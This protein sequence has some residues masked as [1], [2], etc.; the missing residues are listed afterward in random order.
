MGTIDAHLPM[1]DTRV[2]PNHRTDDEGFGIV[3]AFDPKTGEKKWEYKMGDST[4]AAV[5]T[6]ASDLLLSGGRDG[7]FSALN[8]RAGELLRR[9]S[10]GGQINSGPHGLLGEWEAVH[11][12]GW[13]TSLF[14]FA[15]R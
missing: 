5:L 13:G 15:V 4:W 12:R 3:R 7:N 14:A 6:T 10:L 8:A 1:P 9:I 11:H 2:L